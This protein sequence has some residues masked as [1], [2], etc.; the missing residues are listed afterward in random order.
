MSNKICAGKNNSFFDATVW[1]NVALVLTC[2][3]E[4][5]I[6]VDFK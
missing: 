6:K 1:G 5:F 3:P 2:I 4:E